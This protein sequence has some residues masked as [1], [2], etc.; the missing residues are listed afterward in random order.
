MLCMVIDRFQTV[1]ND[2]NTEDELNEICD[3]LCIG[4]QECF[5]EMEF[6][7]NWSFFYQPTS[8]DE[9]WLPETEK[10]DR[11]EALKKQHWITERREQDLISKE[12]KHSADCG[13]CPCMVQ[14][15]DE[16]D[17]NSQSDCDNV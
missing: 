5:M 17:D 4:D 10:H 16:Y 11:N 13:T 2:G 14:S 3:N 8:L 12:I 6:D 7:D 1:F 9:V 15:D